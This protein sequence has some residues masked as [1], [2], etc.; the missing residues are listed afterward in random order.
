M[1]ARCLDQQS[2]VPIQVP[3]DSSPGTPS[4][5]EKAVSS[6]PKKP[7]FE[8]RARGEAPAGCPSAHGSILNEILGRRLIPGEAARISPQP[9]K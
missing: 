2:V 7:S 6:D 5:R 4:T 8:I 3:R 1:L 9:R